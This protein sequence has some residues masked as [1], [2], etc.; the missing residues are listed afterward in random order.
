MIGRGKISR[1]CGRHF[2]TGHANPE[3]RTRKGG[4][5]ETKALEDVHSVRAA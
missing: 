5:R 2:G 3:R 4:Y 1:I